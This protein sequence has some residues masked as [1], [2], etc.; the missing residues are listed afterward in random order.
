MYTWYNPTERNKNLEKVKGLQQSQLKFKEKGRDFERNLVTSLRR[1]RSINQQSW[2]PCTK[3]NT[4]LSALHFLLF[5]ISNSYGPYGCLRFIS[6]I[7][8]ESEKNMGGPVERYRKEEKNRRK[9]VFSYLLFSYERMIIHVS[10]F[11]FLGFN[12]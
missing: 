1:K 12:V 10:N 11:I 5:C 9:V 3:G 4:I 8:L 7:E 2:E 6:G